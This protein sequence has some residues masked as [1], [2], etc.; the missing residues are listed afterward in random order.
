MAYDVYSAGV[1]ILDLENSFQ[2][3]SAYHRL[4]DKKTYN[5][6]QPSKEYID[7]FNNLFD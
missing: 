4:I 5:A 6:S 3:C 2:L 7:A 1:T